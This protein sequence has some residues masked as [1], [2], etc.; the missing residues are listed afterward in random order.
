MTPLRQRFLDDLRLR[1]YAP[2]TIEAYVAG[3]ARFANHFECS[4]ELLGP[5]DVRT[6]QLHLLQQQVSWS[7]FNQTVCALRFFYGTTLG[8]PEQVPFIPF[9][10]RPRT[11]PCVLSPDEVARLFAAAQPGR[12]RVLLQT[13]YACGLRL[14]EV[15]HLQVTDID[16]ARMVLHLRQ[17]KGRKDRLVPL[18]AKLLDE[19]RGYWRQARPPRWLFPGAQAE[20]PL[21]G[22]AVQRW[23]PRLLRQAGLTKPASMHTLRHSYATHLLEAGVDLLTLQKLLGHCQLSTTAHYVHLRC[24][25]WRLLPSLLELLAVPAPSARVAAEGS[26]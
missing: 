26:A 15:L 21:T 14:S 17:C 13:T 18:A 23:W 7:L 22:S 16:S 5:E 3:V 12:E 10:K 4:P 24:D 6:F 9:G 1:N 25:G 20:A 8:R 19:L 11:L 2:G